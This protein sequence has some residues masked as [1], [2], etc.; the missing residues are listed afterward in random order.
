MDAG[1]AARIA[2]I[3]TMLAQ[4][5]RIRL[6]CIGRKGRRAAAAQEVTVV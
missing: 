5:A 1:E 3:G 2:V 6:R 4:Y